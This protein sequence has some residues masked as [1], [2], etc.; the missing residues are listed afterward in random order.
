MTDPIPTKLDDNDGAW[1][2]LLCKRT[3]LKKSEVIRRSVRV[4]AQAA[5]E[6]PKWNWVSE[7]SQP[8]PPLTAE[9]QAEMGDQGPKDFDDANARAKEKAEADRQRHP[10]RGRG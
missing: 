9:Q 6:R 7:T 4:L 1:L 10:R 5:A 2:T 3:G 8:M